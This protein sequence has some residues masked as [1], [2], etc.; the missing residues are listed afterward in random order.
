MFHIVLSADEKYI[1]YAM[2]LIN[3]IVKNTNINKNFIDYIDNTNKENTKKSLKDFS[4]DELQEGYIFHIF[5]DFIKDETKVKMFELSQ[6]LSKIYPCK[7]VI[8]ILTNEIFIQEKIPIWRGGY[9][10][11]FRYFIG[12]ILEENIRHCLYLDIDMLV[13][14]DIRELWTIKNDAYIIMA[15]NYDNYFN[16]GFLFINIANW[17]KEDIQEKS[18]KYSKKY[19]AFDQDSLNAVI[20]KN[21]ILFLSS[22]WNYCLQTYESNNDPIFEKNDYENFIS[23]VKI[24]HYIRPK[25]WMNILQWLKHS[26]GKCFAYQNILDLWWDNAKATPIFSK[27]LSNIKIELNNI[28]SNEI[29]KYLKTSSIKL[30]WTEKF[31]KLLKKY[32][33]K[34]ICAFVPN[35]KYRK[36][37]RR[38]LL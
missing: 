3:S 35:Q 18:L 12:S 11:Y 20:D 22:N 5:S 15:V 38:K 16:S 29:I 2:A 34:I 26:E 37:I 27:E 31:Y 19:L 10:A 23:Q 8:H 24:I 33:V 1:K 13:L 9:Q 6:E 21:K 7:I 25:P 4:E 36:I 32:I 28:F 17:K 14:Q 30:H